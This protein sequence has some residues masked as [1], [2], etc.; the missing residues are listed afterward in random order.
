[1]ASLATAA[2]PHTRL[3]CP[4]VQDGLGAKRRK[5]SKGPCVV[6]ETLGWGEREIGVV[7][8][9]GIESGGHVVLVVLVGH[10]FFILARLV[11][12]RAEGSEVDCW[13][14]VKE[15]RLRPRH[16]RLA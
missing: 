12:R 7:L 1:V 5:A 2:A 10:W 6:L 13:E 15:A 3:G 14:S 11:Q 4:E 16:S 8:F 9:L